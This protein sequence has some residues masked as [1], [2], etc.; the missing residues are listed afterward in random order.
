MATPPASTS[1]SG[2]APAIS[3]HRGGRERAPPGTYDAYRSALAAGA[4]YLEF[5][6]RRTADGELVAFHATGL[7]RGRPV[8]SLSYAD[9]CRL[10]GYGVPT[11]GGVLQLLAGRAS[12]HI[13]LKDRACLAAIVLEAL[14]VLEPEHIIVTTSDEAAISEL[15]NR[16]PAVPAGLT[17]GGDHA[18]TLRYLAERARGRAR[19]R[20]DA[21]ARVG[22]DCAV[23]HERLARAGVL[24]ECRRRGLATMV[25]T[26]NHDTALARWL[27]CPDVDVL[28]TDRPGRAAELRRLA[29]Q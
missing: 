9:L 8:G 11:A 5:D 23:V 24:A 25:W 26:V 29:S 2:L 17:I 6:V 14:R 18:Q 20:I 1:R 21:V 27:S 7:R 16:F 22:A 28:V 12:A 4:D 13:D 10:A 15:R 19:S 3:A